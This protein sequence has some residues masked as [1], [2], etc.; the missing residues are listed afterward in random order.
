M[1]LGVSATGKESDDSVLYTAEGNKVSE[2]LPLDFLGV[3]K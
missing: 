1:S 2:I 3:Q